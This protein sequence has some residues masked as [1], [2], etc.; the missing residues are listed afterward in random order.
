MKK[1]FLSTLF[2]SNLILA[3]PA[4]QL[5]SPAPGGSG[6]VQRFTISTTGSDQGWTA[7]MINGNYG[8]PQANGCNVLVYPGGWVYLGLDN[9]SS[10]GNNS[11]LG[12]STYPASITNSQCILD[13]VGGSATQSGNVWTFAFTITFKPAFSGTKY[14]SLGASTGAG[15]YNPSP[16]NLGTWTTTSGTSAPVTS[17]VSPQAGGTGLSQVFSFST[18]YAGS[19]SGGQTQVGITAANS[20]NGNNGCWF[21]GNQN[22]TAFYLLTDSGSGWMGMNG[23]GVASNLQCTLSNYSVYVS[24]TTT[25]YTFTVTFAPAF[26]GTRYIWGWSINGN[27]QYGPVMYG[28]WT[29]PQQQ[30]D[31]TLSATEINNHELLLDDATG[32]YIEKPTS[33]NPWVVQLRSGLKVKIADA[34]NLKISNISHSWTPTADNAYTY[35]YVIDTRDNPYIMRLGITEDQYSPIG[36]DVPNTHPEGWLGCGVGWV[37][38][39]G[40]AKLSAKSEFSIESKWKPGLQALFVMSHK[41][42]EPIPSFS[43]TED[44]IRIAEVA[45]IFTNSLRKYTIGPALAPDLS[46]EGL[47][48]LLDRWVNDYGFVFLDPLLQGTQTL[49]EIQTN[50]PFEQEILQCLRDFGKA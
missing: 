29:V 1:L 50:D 41:A 37:N 16:S 46:P 21:M 26:A 28:S 38:S 4:V 10:W 13:S 25:T 17:L 40:K 31:M 5:I 3:Q 39:D 8:W 7:L 49:D 43:G 47:R 20:F 32:Q 19:P 18:N 12:D 34:G 45:N 2:F 23:Q 30:L 11:K 33:G 6:S 48:E 36:V 35:H 15:A 24:G 22:G 9:Q 42:K 27:G 14:M 44:N